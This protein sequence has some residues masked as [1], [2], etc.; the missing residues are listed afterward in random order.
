MRKHKHYFYTHREFKL[1]H[2]P[3]MQVSAYVTDEKTEAERALMACS[4]MTCS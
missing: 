3:A 1:I 4:L 2:S